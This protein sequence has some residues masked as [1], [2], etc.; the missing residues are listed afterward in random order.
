M[1]MKKKSKVPEAEK[2][3]LADNAATSSIDS[4]YVTINSIT[5]NADNQEV[6]AELDEQKGRHFWFVVYPT[7]TWLRANVPDLT[8]DG[9][10]GWGTA[11]DDW[12]EQL[13]NTGL[14]FTVSPLHCYDVNADGTPKK[15]HWHVIVSWGNTT[16]YR[17]A[18]ALC[19]LLKSP[20]PKLLKNV[21]GAYRYHKHLDNPEK[22][23][24]EDDKWTKSYNGWTPPLDSSNVTRIKSE[25]Y[26]LV[27]D[28]DI[29]EYAELLVVCN[30]LGPEYFD[31]ACNN[32]FY[33]EKIC[34]S[35]RHNPVR[36]LMRYYN[37]LDEG[38]KKEAIRERIEQYVDL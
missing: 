12:Q 32:T 25:I 9:S 23:Q 3:P 6:F 14:P 10:S 37:T 20:M 2:K 7:E 27:F 30:M 34:S 33:C 28:E 19:D 21:T 22:Y 35:Y 24:Y 16:T 31:V 26:A 38:E 29:Q 13:Q 18:R 4:D 15:P 1:G 11:P 8:Y 17:S 5:K 36:S